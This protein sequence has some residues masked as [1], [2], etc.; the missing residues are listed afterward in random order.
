[1]PERN[2]R[3]GG[4]VRPL[5]KVKAISGEQLFLVRVEFFRDIS[6]RSGKIE[7]IRIQPRENLSGRA[8]ESRIDRGGLSAIGLA[9]PKS[10]M[11]LVFFYDLHRIVRGTAVHH[12]IFEIWI[13]L[14]QDGFNRIG[15]ECALVIRGGDHRDAGENF[16][17]GQKSS[18]TI[19]PKFPTKK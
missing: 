9:A 14:T 16:H 19:R 3:A 13:S 12:E 17:A 2:E 1:V 4:S 6:E 18:L 8:L 15:Q 5:D 11:L 10:E 7:I